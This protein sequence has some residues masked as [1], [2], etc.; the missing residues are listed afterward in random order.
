MRP[1]SNTTMNATGARAIAHRRPVDAVTTTPTT[2]ARIIVTSACEVVTGPRGVRY[3]LPSANASTLAMASIVAGVLRFLVA[4]PLPPTAD[5]E[6]PDRRSATPVNRSGYSPRAAGDSAGCPE[7]GG[8]ARVSR[9]GR[10]GLDATLRRSF[11]E[12]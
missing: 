6:R 4:I 12:P 8:A 10:A 9:A 3:A 1:T 11:A 7:V 5:A 2:S